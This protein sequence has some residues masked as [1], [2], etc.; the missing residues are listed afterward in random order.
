MCQLRLLFLLVL[1]AHVVQPVTAGEIGR[2]KA[3]CR[4][5]EVVALAGRVTAVFSDCIY[6]EDEDRTSGIRLRGYSTSEGLICIF[7]SDGANSGLRIQTGTD[8]ERELVYL[9]LTVTS[10][11]YAGVLAPLTLPNRSVGG[12]DFSYCAATGRGQMGVCGGCGLNTVGLLVRTCGRVL[13]VNRDERCFYI[14][15]GSRCC[16]G[17]GHRGIRVDYS[18]SNYGHPVFVGDFCSR[19]TGICTTYIDSVEKRPHPMIKLRP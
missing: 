6:L 13:E 9:P 4:D 2:L 17:D 18:E 16:G 10:V 11:V 7:A 19:V 12:G 1:A 3:T 14:D 15:D 8:G 5:G